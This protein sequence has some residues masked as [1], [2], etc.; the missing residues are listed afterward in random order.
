VLEV[1]VLRGLDDA[2]GFCRIGT[3]WTTIVRLARTLGLHRF[4]E[5]KLTKKCRHN[6]RMLTAQT[7]PLLVSSRTDSRIFETSLDNVAI[8]MLLTYEIRTDDEGFLFH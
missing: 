5:V 2:S 8:S 4:P 7:A 3:Q 6:A 1:N